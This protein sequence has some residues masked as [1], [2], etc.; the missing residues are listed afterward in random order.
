MYI[1]KV[2]DL[3]VEQDAHSD[4]RELLLV[5]KITKSGEKLHNRPIFIIKLLKIAEQTVIDTYMTEVMYTMS[6]R[7]MSECDK[8]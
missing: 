1:P 3:V 5:L 7:L 4:Y 8:L 2:G 6:W